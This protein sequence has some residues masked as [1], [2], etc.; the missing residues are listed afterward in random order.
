LWWRALVAVSSTY[1]VVAGDSL[2]TL[3][4]RVYD[5]AALWPRIYQ[6]NK[7]VIGDNPDALWRGLELKIPPKS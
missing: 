1:T 6:A 5:D 3:A 2:V 7:D 4:E